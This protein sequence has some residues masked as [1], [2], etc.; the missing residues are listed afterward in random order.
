[1]VLVVIDVFILMMLA[2]GDPDEE[3]LRGRTFG[4]ID[5]RRR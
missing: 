1:V 4:S 5:R 3:D 2:D